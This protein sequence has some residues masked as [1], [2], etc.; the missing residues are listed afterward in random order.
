MPTDRQSAVL[1]RNKGEK[2]KALRVQVSEPRKNCQLH[3]QRSQ[4]S[5][6]WLVGTEEI[7]FHCQGDW[8]LSL[9][10]LTSLHL[11]LKGCVGSREN[12]DCH[13]ALDFPSCRGFGCNMGEIVS[14]HHLAGHC[15]SMFQRC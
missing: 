5:L 7:T 12:Q 4:T 9:S 2:G 14:S 10:A 8:P 11:L 13:G 6:G 3:F 1:T 15:C